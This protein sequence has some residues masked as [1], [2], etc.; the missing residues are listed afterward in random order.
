MR[1]ANVEVLFMLLFMVMERRLEVSFACQWSVYKER[2]KSGF[3]FC[4]LNRRKLFGD[5]VGESVSFC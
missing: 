4:C 5:V 2:N 1:G 3:F